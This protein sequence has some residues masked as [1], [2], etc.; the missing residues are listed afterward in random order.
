MAGDQGCRQPSNF[1]IC[2][3]FWGKRLL[4]P[5]ETEIVPASLYQFFDVREVPMFSWK[6]IYAEIAAKLPEFAEQSRRLVSLM[7][8]LHKR[9]LKVSSVTDKDKGGVEVPMDEVDPFSFFA[10]FNRGVTDDNRR[11]IL[12]A[13]KKEWQLVSD[14]P[15]DFDGLPLMSAQN[16][17]FMPY[18]Y[19]RDTDH[20]SKLWDFFTHCQELQSE[21]DLDTQ[22]FDA[23]CALHRVAPASLTMGMFWTRPDLWISVDKKNREFAVSLG[24]SHVV[25]TG[26]DYLQ[27]LKKV[28]AKTDK[29][30]CEFSFQA[31]LNSLEENSDDD[32]N[33]GEEIDPSPPA[34]RR[35]YWLLAPGRGANL[36]DTWYAEGIGGLGWNDMEDLS[37][38]ESKEAMAEYVPQVYEEAGPAAVAHML[39]DFAHEMKPG[40]IVFAK[41]GLHKICG[42]GVITGDYEY[43]ESREPFY[44]IRRIEWKTSTEVTM[45]TGD[46]LPLKTITRMTSKRPFLQEMVRRYDAIPGLES[47]LRPVGPP[48]PNPRQPVHPPYA[49]SDAMNDV[50]MPI[51]QVKSC[52]ELLQRK[53]NIVLQGAPGTGKTFVAKRLA[54]L[55][56]GQKDDSRVQMVQFHQSMTYEDFVQGYKPSGDGGFK[57]DNGS[58]HNFVDAALA[59]PTL[60]FV[61]II[62]EINRGN[63]SKVFGELMMLI[64]PDKRS[65]DFAIP[66]SYSSDLDATFYVPPNVHLIGTMNTADRSLSMVD[67]ALRR[68]FAFVELDPGFESPVFADVLKKSEA[69]EEVVSDV[70]NRMKLINEMIVADK[71]NLGRGYRIGHSFFCPL[72]G[73]PANSDW[74]QQILQFEIK[75]LLEEYYC[76]DPVQLSAA[77]EVVNGSD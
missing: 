41:R 14:V 24:I 55:L 69:T 21:Y 11:A 49:L 36:W 47:L 77:L 26:A 74:L 1:D 57:L 76:D 12:T 18:K 73:K 10:N 32:E 17:W 72:D 16:S 15:Q 51:E 40:D 9:G 59:K 34:V 60:P 48:V 37:E 28:K 20:V 52:V 71:S 53:K 42:W 6:P 29:S 33:E 19:L 7:I 45:P 58:F 63:M 50:F 13:I 66:L 54:Y 44:N 67:Y 31:H 46:Q 25:V 68:R 27:W 8:Q 61:F 75:P 23:C 70:R 3:R 38:Y 64:E 35:N 39:W 65:S 43:D 4:S 5:F 62:D 22:K 2:S 30:T 56:M